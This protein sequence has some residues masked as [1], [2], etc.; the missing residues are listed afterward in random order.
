MKITAIICTYNEE[1]HIKRCIEVLKNICCQIIVLDSYSTDKTIEIAKSLGVEVYFK[2][3]ITFSEKLNYAINNLIINGD[4]VL[5]IDADEYFDDKAIK[6]IKEINSISN[7]INGFRITRKIKFLGKV[8][9]DSSSFH[10]KIWRKGYALCEERWMDERMILKSGKQ[11]KIEGLVIDDNLFSLRDWINKHSNYAVKE[12]LDI[13]LMDNNLLTNNQ[14]KGNFFGKNEE[15]IRYFKTIYSRFPLF[16]RPMPLF[17]YKYL[18][19]GGFRS[20]IEGLI[21]CFLQSFW[22]RFL[23]DAIIYDC[24]KNHFKNDAAVMN[25]FENKYGI[26]IKAYGIK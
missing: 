15:S 8:M 21:W 12:A 7:D 25:Y 3:Y 4:W 20:G 18:I 24:N 16:I 5:R 22:Y 14:L 10:L 19:K 17:L 11:E 1:I 9:R 6:S 26:N 13:Y 23:V 2:E